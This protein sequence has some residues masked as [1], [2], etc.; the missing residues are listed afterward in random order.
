[1]IFVGGDSIWSAVVVF[2]KKLKVTV[3]SKC[4]KC[5]CDEDTGVVRVVLVSLCSI[6]RQYSV[7][8]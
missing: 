2:C 6:Y 8:T 5:G 4:C 3:L 1:M 7:I